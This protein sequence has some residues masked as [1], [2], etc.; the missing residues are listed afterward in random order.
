MA[1]LLAM[2]IQHY[3]GGLGPSTGTHIPLTVS[4]LNAL[5][6]QCLEQ[7]FSY[8]CIEGEVSNVAKPSSGHIYF[9]LKDERA[10]VR[11]VF[12]KPNQSSSFQLQ[13]G[14]HVLIKGKIGLYQPRGDYQVT[15]YS[16]EEAGVGALLRAYEALKKRLEGEGLFD[17]KIKKIIPTYPESIGVITA[18]QGAA[19]Q[20]VLATL[21]RRYPLAKVNIYPTLVQG[22]EAKSLII[23]ALQKAD[24]AGNDTLILCRG[25]GSIEDLWVFNEEELIR[26]LHA[27]KTPIIT[28]I[29]HETD[30]TL[31]DEV[32]DKRAPTPTAAA[33]LCTPQ[34]HDLIQHIDNLQRRLCFQ[35]QQILITKQQ[36]L[37]SIQS[38]LTHPSEQIAKYSHQVE[39]L[40]SKLIY[41]FNERISQLKLNLEAHRSI[42]YQHH[43]KQ[44]LAHYTAKHQESH[45]NLLNTMHTLMSAKKSHFALLMSALDT[46]S[47]LS[48][49]KRGYTLVKQNSQTVTHCTD[50]N[51]NTPIEVHFHDGFIT[52]SPLS[53]TGDE[54]NQAPT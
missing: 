42:L 21:A 5:V 29:G 52:A 40:H 19:I 49:L 31:S 10:Q 47:P 2:K 45:H 3:P 53:V 39:K 8:L 11:C 30:T 7:S 28:G 33:E 9:T 54:K 20:D 37:H 46:L 12:F 23:K 27:C 36:Q 32:A 50:I 38:K 14:Q 13:A 1:Y 25:G 18:P 4:E 48:T 51:P 24:N 15:V 34:A 22:Q 35:I 43:P 44:L 26:A 17:S 41:L 6:K 16:C